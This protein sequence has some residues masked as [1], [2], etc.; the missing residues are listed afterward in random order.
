LL[1]DV[2]DIEI[3]LT[4]SYTNCHAEVTEKHNIFKTNLVIV[5]FLED[6]IEILNRESSNMPY[7]LPP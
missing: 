1:S 2:A 3:F 6:N 5:L 7:M 4:S